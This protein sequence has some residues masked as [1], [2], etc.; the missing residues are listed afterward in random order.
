MTTSAGRAVDSAP[1]GSTGSSTQAAGMTDDIGALA[2]GQPPAIGLA[3]RDRRVRRTPRGAPA[4]AVSASCGPKAGVPAGQR[5][6]SRRTA[7]A[8]PGHGSNGSTGA[9]VPNAR[10]APVAA[11]DPHV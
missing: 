11:I 7:R 2:D 3:R 9:S 6:S 5:R 1:P 8:M 10:T 4:R